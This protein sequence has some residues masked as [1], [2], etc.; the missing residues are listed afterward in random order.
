MINVDFNLELSAIAPSAVGP[1]DAVGP[2][3]T[4]RNIHSDMTFIHSETAVIGTALTPSDEIIVS[5]IP[6]LRD[7]PFFGAF[8][9]ATRKRELSTS[10]FATVHAR[11]VRDNQ[12]TLEESIRRRLGF[13]RA[14]SRSAGLTRNTGAAYAVRV[15][16]TTELRRAEAIADYLGSPELELKIVAWKFLGQTHFDVY[17]V[18]I[19]SLAEASQRTTEAGAAGWRAELIA[20]P[21]EIEG[22]SPHHSAP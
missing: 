15:A 4:Q 12:E 16:S 5:G 10:L 11:V 20:L 13:E 2:T 7:I 22:D 9:R 14:L 18:G 1:I 8:F 17:I 3:L 21:D 19:D 6:W